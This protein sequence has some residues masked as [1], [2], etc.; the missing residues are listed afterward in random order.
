MPI[1][2]LCYLVLAIFKNLLQLFFFCVNKNFLKFIFYLG[3]TANGAK[4]DLTG[5]HLFLLY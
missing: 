5:L 2:M 4:V 3:N 1:N